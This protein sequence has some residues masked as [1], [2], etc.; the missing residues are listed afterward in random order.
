MATEIGELVVQLK[1]STA[2]FSSDL[3]VAHAQTIASI[4]GMQSA[5]DLLGQSFTRLGELVTVSAVTYA[6]GLAV[7]LD[8]I[9]EWEVKMGHLAES[10]GTSVETMSQLAFASKML[11]LDI[12]QVGGAMEKFDKNLLSL[13]TG[14]G[15]KAFKEIM[16]G[17]DPAS[18]KDSDQALKIFA[19]RFAA[20]PD[21][22][23]KT[24]IA[25][26]AFG[27]GAAAIIPYL[28]E[29]SAGIERMNEI[30]KVT[31]VVLGDD[32][33][34]GAEKFQQGMTELGAFVTGFQR[35]V[36]DALVPN[37]NAL[38]D[39]LLKS[40]EAS[41]GQSAAFTS[42]VFVIQALATAA[43]AGAETFLLF[44]DVVGTT[45]QHAVLEFDAMA[46]GAVAL[47]LALLGDFS[48]A[49]SWA[50]GMKDEWAL[51]EQF[52][53][54]GAAAITK[55]ATQAAELLGDIWGGAA[56][57]KN[58]P[59]KPGGGGSGGSGDQ[60]DA[61]AKLQQEIDRLDASLKLSIA[62]FG[63]STDKINLYKIANLQASDAVKAH[64]TQEALLLQTL[65]L[66]KSGNQSHP[67]EIQAPDF[68]TVIL[69]SNTQEALDKMAQLAAAQQKIADLSVD[70]DA[71]WKATASDMTTE[72]AQLGIGA[73]YT[74]QQIAKLIDPKTF[75]DISKATRDFEST[76]ERTFESA[77]KGGK[78]FQDVLKGLISDLEIAILKAAVF[79]PLFGTGKGGNNG[80]LGGALNSLTNSFSG[81]FSGLFGG[82]G[83]ATG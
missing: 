71:K 1:A 30:A 56:G 36:T 17:I 75:Q 59:L 22:V 48:G 82:A 78:S 19:D 13:Q 73:Q 81:L 3:Q 8:K 21:G 74:Q 16:K 29:G 9:T 24:G 62:T 20:M 37:L 70:I 65:D 7:P 58:N 14:S 40:G 31:G 25:M 52:S 5:V 72:F 60:A 11:G 32:A 35:Q 39:T 23:Q 61:S 41:K 54:D 83:A 6:A 68:S 45:A 64:L 12:D 80:L 77:I 15:S 46:H 49:K 28:N 67:T 43:L 18:I 57:M 50:Q 44:G 38:V 55:D 34:K 66:F 33:Y 51:A 10:A 76:I 4:G 47:G 53:K 27:K 69:G 63:F 2:Q 79:G 26:T 42:A